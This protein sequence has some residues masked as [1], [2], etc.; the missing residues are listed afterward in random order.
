MSVGD[1]ALEPP[2]PE[3]SVGAGKNVEPQPGAHH[4]GVA[5]VVEDDGAEGIRQNRRKL[6]KSV[7]L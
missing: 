5:H 7:G 4:T 1:P 2:E 3:D 6:L